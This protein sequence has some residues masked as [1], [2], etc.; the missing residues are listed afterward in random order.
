MSRHTIIGVS[1]SVL[2]HDVDGEAGFDLYFPYSQNLTAGPFYVVRTE[3]NPMS[4]ATAATQ[5]I[6]ATDPNQSF[7][8]V[9]TFEGRIQNRI[10]QRRLSAGLFGT[11]A[12]LALVLAGTG[13]YGI[14]SYA[15]LQQTREIGVRVALGARPADVLKGVVGRGF[16]LAAIGCCLGLP[17]AFMLSNLIAGLLFEVAPA[18]YATYGAAMAVLLAISLA[19]C[20][21]PARRALR[22]DPISALRAE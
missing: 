4:I 7:L 14:L 5:I 17:L 3:T 22:V 2:H 9:Q 18:H 20:W 10:W 13:L 21:L 15:V 19:A 11:F 8:D 16:V 12:V 6:G 1:D